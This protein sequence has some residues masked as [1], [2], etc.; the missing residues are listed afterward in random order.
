MNKEIKIKSKSGK[1]EEYVLDDVDFLYITE[2]RQLKEIIKELTT[3]I[4][5][6]QEQLA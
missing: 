1:K 6:L 2:L 3:S 4:N 5:K